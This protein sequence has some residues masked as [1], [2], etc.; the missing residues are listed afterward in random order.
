MDYQNINSFLQNL[1][2]VEDT[3]KNIGN[4]SI[5]CRKNVYDDNHPEN[6]V[7]YNKKRQ[8]TSQ[9]ILNRNFQ[10][11]P[12]KY[13][14]SNYKDRINN[15]NAKSES[16]LVSYSNHQFERNELLKTNS[17][18][19]VMDYNMFSE[20]YRNK[21]KIEIDTLNEK[22]NSRDAIPSRLF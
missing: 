10:F 6:I 22:M 7:T 5:T 11:V 21:D 8:E 13:V 1:K 4:I 15:V 9:K 2:I 14:P 19:P 18:V 12:T 17:N 20:N 16:N 3:S